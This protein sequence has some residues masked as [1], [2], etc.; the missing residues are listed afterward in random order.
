MAWPICVEGEISSQPNG[1]G[2]V[3]EVTFLNEAMIRALLARAKAPRF[4]RRP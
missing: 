3:Q 2:E 4:W 1:G